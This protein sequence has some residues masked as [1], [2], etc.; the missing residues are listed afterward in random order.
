[1]LDLRPGE[2]RHQRYLCSLNELVFHGLDRRKIHFDRVFE[3]KLG[4]DQECEII[5]EVPNKGRLDG[6]ASLP[7]DLNLFEST[8][9]GVV[10]SSGY[11]NPVRCNCDTHDLCFHCCRINH[12]VLAATISP[13]FQFAPGLWIAE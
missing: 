3:G 5:P 11:K 1:M 4:F 6:I 10:H 13:V 7:D 8:G 2:V 12:G 9:Q